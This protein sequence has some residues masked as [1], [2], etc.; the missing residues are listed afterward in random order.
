VATSPTV[1]GGG[2]G[3][4]GLSNNGVIS[5]NTIVFNQTFNQGQNVSGG[6]ISISGGNQ[7]VGANTLTSGSGNVKIDANLIQG[8]HAGAGDGGGIMLQG[9]NGDDVANNPNDHTQWYQV[10]V[11]NNMIVNNV[12]G[13]AGGGVAL[14]DALNVRIVNNTIAHNDSTGTGSAAFTRVPRDPNHSQ[15]QPGA[16][17]SSRGTTLGLQAVIGTPGLDYEKPFSNPKITN[18]II[19]QNRL[20]EWGIVPVGKGQPML[21]G[22]TPNIA[23]G[24]AP[25]FSDLA[26]HGVA[27]GK[28]VESGVQHSYIGERL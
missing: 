5:H 12:T 17:V 11:L 22:L 24:D 8:N 18:N 2:I 7:I 9:V 27:G 6:G 14:Q 1:P 10:D 26:V 23:A 19:W 15:M 16:G 13:V 25:V 28:S 21:F 3:H 4:L 20:F